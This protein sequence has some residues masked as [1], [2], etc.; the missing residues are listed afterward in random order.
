MDNQRVNSQFVPKDTRRM[1]IE[2]TSD[3]YPFPPAELWEMDQTNDL[4]YI[5]ELEIAYIKVDTHY[6]V[7]KWNQLFLD[8]V[9][10]TKSELI[11][12]RLN[13]LADQSFLMERMYDL[14]NQSLQSKR[15]EVN[16]YEDKETILHLRA[17]PNEDL[18]AVYILV[19][20]RSIQKQFEN[21]LTFHH[22]MEAVSHIAAG[23]A[24][25]L[26][27]PL[28]VIKGFFQL[29]QLTNEYQKYYDTILAE[30]N[31]MNAIIEDFLSVSRR[32]MERK[33]QSPVE[34]LQSL[35]EIMKAECLLHNVEFSMHL[36][37]T[38][39]QINVNES[40]IKQIML[41]LLRNSIEAFG[42]SNDKR[43]FEVNTEINRD[44][45]VVFIRD[46]G[47]GMPKEVLQQL[48]KPFFTT[49][50]QGTGIGIPLCKKMIEDHGGTFKIESTFNVG[51]TVILSVPLFEA[52]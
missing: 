15:V 46:N 5:E 6:H 12:E 7:K 50:A 28:S 42:K 38:A 25:E 16:H 45:Y 47:K 24:H 31:R 29:A 39:L 37:E 11:Y 1:T 20:D 2:P 51:T 27:N 13:T 52:N 34:I 4:K 35:V 19:E 48:G 32:K 40:I 17:L 33:L 44:H 36:K 18:S 43:E 21:L 49:K 10:I 14:L 22:Q 8:I 3:Q 30:L 41:N 23:V 9:D 26:R